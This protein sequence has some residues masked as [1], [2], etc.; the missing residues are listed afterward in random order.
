VPAAAKLLVAEFVVVFS[1]AG[2]PSGLNVHS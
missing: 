2:F 1:V